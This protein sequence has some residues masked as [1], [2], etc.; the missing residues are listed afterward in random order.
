MSRTVEEVDRQGRALHVVKQLAQR[1]AVKTLLIALGQS[2]REA[3]LAEPHDDDQL[4]RLRL[5]R[6]AGRERA[7]RAARAHQFRADRIIQQIPVFVLQPEGRDRHQVGVM[8]R[9]DELQGLELLEALAA[10]Q[11]DHLER[12]VNAPRSAR[13]PD[14]AKIAATQKLDQ[15]VAGYRFVMGSVSHR[16]TDH[17]QDATIAQDPGEKSSGIV[18]IFRCLGRK[19][20][21]PADVLSPLSSAQNARRS[22]QRI[23]G[24][25]PSGHWQARAP[26]VDDAS[27]DTAGLGGTSC[28]RT[29]GKE[30]ILVE[31]AG[32]I[33]IRSRARPS[34]IACYARVG[35]Q[36]VRRIAVRVPNGFQ[37]QGGKSLTNGRIG[38]MPQPVPSSA[39]G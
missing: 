31:S 13:F 30:L 7:S 2:I 15:H 19:M 33:S 3:H 21:P 28:A 9:L 36:H 24:N 6:Q 35:Q 1:D 17:S 16:N 5:P 12:D 25:G 29:H 27:R 37:F 11:V 32:R 34:E 18:P 8:D 10:P 4:A 22:G 14:L 20:P 26:A 39:D 38:C 23:H